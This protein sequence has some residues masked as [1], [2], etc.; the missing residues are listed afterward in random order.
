MNC[1]SLCWPVESA[2][3]H[4]RNVVSQTE[5]PDSP[6]TPAQKCFCCILLR[7]Q[8]VTRKRWNHLTAAEFATITQ[9]ASVSKRC[10]RLVLARLQCTLAL[11]PDI[12]ALVHV[13][14]HPSICGL[15]VTYSQND[16]TGFAVHNCGRGNAAPGTLFIID[17]LKAEPPCSRSCSNPHNVPGVL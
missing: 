15:W 8:L 3:Q 4:K 5:Q 12:V 6:S 9:K 16:R 14:S 17:S 13:N 2:R 1:P 10:Q 11:W 7:L